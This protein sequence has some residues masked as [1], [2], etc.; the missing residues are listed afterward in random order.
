MTANENCL[1]C[2]IVANVIPARR[3][4]EDVHVVAFEDINPQAPTHLL[5][6][7]RKHIA[8]T[9]ELGP[10]DHEAIG[11]VVTRAA[12]LARDHHLEN[13]GYRMVMNC[14]ANA[15]QTVFHIHLH[16]LGGRV[17]SWPPG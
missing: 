11:R 14:G 5:V 6:I 9:D 1:F 12:A 4:F 13:D 7:P 16:L 3:V 10:A 8:S 17:F 2:K 15:G